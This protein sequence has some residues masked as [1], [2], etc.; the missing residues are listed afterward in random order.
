MKD[1]ET[2]RDV[3]GRGGDVRERMEMRDTREGEK[4]EKSKRVLVGVRQEMFWRL[5]R[6]KDLRITTQWTKNDVA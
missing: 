4:N 6:G 3:Q 2:E 5:D 1:K